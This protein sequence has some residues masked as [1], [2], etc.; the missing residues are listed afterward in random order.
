M[1]KD[2]FEQL[3]SYYN[4]E[5]DLSNITVALCNSNEFFREKFIHFF[6]PQIVIADI[7][8]IE[9][10][11]PDKKGMGSRVDILIQLTNDPKPYLIEVKINDQNHH[12]GQYEDAYDVDKGRLGYITNYDCIEGKL[13]AYD[14]KTWEQ[15]Y[16]YM[17]SVK[18]ADV[19]IIGYL[20][21]LSQVCGIIDIRQRLVLN[22][23]AFKE[24]ALGIFSSLCSIKT[25]T[26][27]IQR[28][29]RFDRDTFKMVD[30]Y[31]GYNPESTERPP[32]YATIEFNY[33]DA[34]S[35]FIRLY[36]TKNS[37]PEAYEFLLNS[38]NAQEGRTF[39]KGVRFKWWGDNVGFYLKSK[40]FNILASPSEQVELLRDFIEE[41]LTRVK[42]R[43]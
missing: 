3:S 19:L 10:E 35:P 9:R 16:H 1:L 40:L 14:V 39:E 30:F 43:N 6:F 29:N 28:R 27:I 4:L 32:Y 20:K 25:E 42:P 41:V 21:F 24:K 33:S 18:T 13:Q 15:F 11:V 38:N 26:L 23:D 36:F 37:N 31:Y 2:F 7:E 22:D 17:A 5:N 34:E 12:F 8:S